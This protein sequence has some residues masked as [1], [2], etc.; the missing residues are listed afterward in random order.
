MKLI[1]Q[2]VA[3][4]F[5][6]LRSRLA[7]WLGVMAAKF[8]IGVWVVLASN[9]SDRAL[10]N[11]QGGVVGLIVT[12][13]ALT[14]LFGALLAQE[15]SVA[16]P[17]AFWRTRPISGTRLLAAK[18]LG[19]TLLLIVPAVLLAVPWWLLCGLGAGDVA[20]AAIEVIVFQGLLL[21]LA[22]TVA[23][24]TDTLA[25][26]FVWGLV[27]LAASNGI[28]G[29]WSYW[30]LK[31]SAAL[32][33]LPL[34]LHGVFLL[35]VMGATVWWQY[36][37]RRRPVGLAM[38]LSGVVLAPAV[39]IVVL[40]RVIPPRLSPPAMWRD[41][42]DLTNGVKI[43]WQSARVRE[44]YLGRRLAEIGL[45]FEAGGVP[46]GHLVRGW[47]ARHEVNWGSGGSMPLR[48]NGG[49][50]ENYLQGIATLLR[51]WRR[52]GGPP[53]EPRTAQVRS[54]VMFDETLVPRVRREPLDFEVELRLQLLRPER[55]LE[56]PAVPGPW[57]LRQG[58][59]FRVVRLEP[60]DYGTKVVV[61]ETEPLG[62]A[63]MLWKE[64]VMGG[65]SQR[66]REFVVE[67]PLNPSPAVVTGRW[68]AAGALGGVQFRQRVIDVDWRFYRSTRE[69]VGSGTT[70]G[71]MLTMVDVPTVATF[72][73]RVA[74]PRMQVK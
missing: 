18:V 4:D 40:Q 70:A 43:T 56:R 21:L 32:G 8:A 2:I 61:L 54:W 64:G 23:S 34:V 16:G 24:V 19:A 29:A 12:D 45:T 27:G 50:G 9:A 7:V 25:R 73:R 69:A 74:V 52:P 60:Y 36:T 30:L 63:D 58:R 15:D 53:T 5:R 20:L 49:G 38:L 31:S 62:I 35:P 41:R 71:V 28:A 59:G 33:N 26:C 11:L 57:C 3:K 72:T 65:A 51:D 17:A 22:F 46:A 68:L 44:A 67:S 48:Q 47:G 1:L 14:L 6:F 55:M 37:T 13:A 66:G 10:L 42:P 39:V